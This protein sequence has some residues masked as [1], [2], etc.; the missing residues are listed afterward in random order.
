MPVTWVERIRRWPAARV[1]VVLAA[2]VTIGTVAGALAGATR[3]GSP[4]LTWGGVLLLVVSGAVTVMRRR[5]PIPVLLVSGAAVLWYGIAR[6][7]DPPLELGALLAIYTVGAQCSRRTIAFMVVVGLA[8]A[9][10]SVV[11]SRD[12]T[13]DSL[14]APLL[15]SLLAVALGDRSRVQAAYVAATEERAR[16]IERE[17]EYETAHAAAGERTRI[18]RELHDVVAHHVSLMVIQAEAGA[19]GCERAGTDP[20]AFDRIAAAGRAALGE[21]RRVLG[22]LRDDDRSSGPEAPQPGLAGIDA[23]ARGVAAA[24]IPVEVR[25]EGVARPLP[26]GVELSAYRIVQEALTN[27]VRHAGGAGAIVIVRFETDAL[28]VEVIDA[29]GGTPI[30]PTT[31]RVGRGLVGVRERVQVLGGSLE[32]GPLAEGGFR[33]AARLPVDG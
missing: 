27:V 8:G 1:D 21:L 11:L 3:S 28:V 31:G 10:A 15:S 32:A 2:L 17:H 29:G 16:R 24:G 12:A 22:V 20:A 26:T 18:A 6:Q 7:P 14:Y 5:F 9:V 33:V 13:P 4:Q 30:A 25:N 19:A 23:L